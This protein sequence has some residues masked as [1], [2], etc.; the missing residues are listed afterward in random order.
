[1]SKQYT[2]MVIGECISDAQ[3]KEFTE[4]ALETFREDVIPGCK[5]FQVLTE[6]GGCMVVLIMTFGTREDCLGYHSSRGYRQFVAKTQH[7]LVGNF[8]IKLF[9]DVTE[10]SA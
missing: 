2:R 8:V 4:K 9:Q 1:M 10:V 6:E 7:L 3:V 5:Q